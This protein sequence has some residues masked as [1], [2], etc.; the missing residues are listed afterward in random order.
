MITYE[1]VFRF[2]GSELSEENSAVSGIESPKKTTKIGIRSFGAQNSL[3][4]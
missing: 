1:N 3:G 4:L 2:S